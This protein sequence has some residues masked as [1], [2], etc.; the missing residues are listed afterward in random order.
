MELAFENG[1]RYIIE[2]LKVF[3]VV[4]YVWKMQPQ[5]TIGIA[6]TASI[7]IR[8]NTGNKLKS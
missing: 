3:L 6:F 1:I 8:I 7:D 4:V 2:L 5:K